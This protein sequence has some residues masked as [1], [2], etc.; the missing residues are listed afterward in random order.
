MNSSDLVLCSSRPP[1]N[2][3]PT[4]YVFN[5]R[6][7][8]Y[9]T[10]A[11]R[12]FLSKQLVKNRRDLRQ[13]SIKCRQDALNAQTPFIIRIKWVIRYLIYCLLSNIRTPYR[14]HIDPARICVDRCT[15]LT[16]CKNLYCG[17]VLLPN[18]I[19][20]SGATPFEINFN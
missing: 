14:T 18:G 5:F 7:F 9:C 2:M 15:E 8:P 10:Y 3:S 17:S 4:L 16:Y 12:I 1:L 11:P 20:S 6:H 19:V 13:I